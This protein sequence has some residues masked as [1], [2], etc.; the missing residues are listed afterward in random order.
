[1]AREKKYYFEDFLPSLRVE[2]A[3]PALSRE[4]IIEYAKRYDPQPF[5][6]DEE[7][8]RHSIFGGLIASGWHIVS[9][10]MRL[11]CDAYLLDAASLGSPEVKPSLPGIAQCPRDTRMKLLREMIKDVPAFML[12]AA[13][14]QGRRSKH[15]GDRSSRGLGPIDHPQARCLGIQGPLDEIGK[16][17]TY[18][19]RVLGAALPNSQ[20]LFF[21]L[22]VDSQANEHHP[23]TEVDA[24]D[25]DHGNNQIIE[26]S[27]IV[28]HSLRHRRSDL[29][30]LTA[31]RNM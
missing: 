3:G 10:C 17:G 28:Q 16:K 24:I 19:A 5:H 4:D 13:W 21:S 1:M 22:V 11:M 23:V 18:D 12:L 26:R 20:E 2:L 14:N 6:V 25:H 8:A 9:L 29:Q 27:A 31:H 7:Q 30:D 15:I